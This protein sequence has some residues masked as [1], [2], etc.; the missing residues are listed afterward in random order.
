MIS[1]KNRIAE[2]RKIKKITQKELAKKIGISRP[3]LSKL[4]NGKNEPGGNLILLGS[5]HETE[6][7]VR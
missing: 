4:E 3:Y 2:L 7:I 6:K 1:L 5:A